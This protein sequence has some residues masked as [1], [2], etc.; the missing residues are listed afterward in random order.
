MLNR[1]RLLLLL[2]RSRNSHKL[3][4]SPLPLSQTRLLSSA[5]SHSPPNLTAFDE[6]WQKLT[7]AERDLVA[8]EYEY[9]QKGD[10]NGLTIDQ[11]KI[12]TNKNSN[13][14][15]NFIVIVILSIII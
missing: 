10:W 15:Y 11:K 4:P 3:T 7:Q 2:C 12:R 8:K 9:L 13:S 5:A 14:Y 1:S 6:R